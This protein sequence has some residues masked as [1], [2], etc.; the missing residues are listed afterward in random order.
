V[1]AQA[2]KACVKH[3]FWPKMNL[4]LIRAVQFR[5]RTGRYPKTLAEIKIDSADPMSGDKLR[6]VVDP[7]GI[8]IYS[9][10][11]DAIENGGPL[12][13]TMTGDGKRDLGVVFPSSRRAKALAD[14]KTA[15]N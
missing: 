15:S 6:Y 8:Q 10:G 5:N 3:E 12:V 7:A 13:R 9:I 2:D 1:F 11:P 14:L 4:A